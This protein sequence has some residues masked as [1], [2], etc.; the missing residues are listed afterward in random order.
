[1]VVVVVGWGLEGV[2]EGADVVK[3]ARRT[4]LGGGDVCKPPRPRAPSLVG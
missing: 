2:S 3:E 1:M 4:R